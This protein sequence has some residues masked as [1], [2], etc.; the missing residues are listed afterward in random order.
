MS[1]ATKDAVDEIQVW[2]DVMTS[3]E[4]ETLPVA[5]P[6]ALVATALAHFSAD[7]VASGLTVG[8]A[9]EHIAAIMWGEGDFDAYTAE[10]SWNIGKQG[11]RGDATGLL[12]GIG[13]GVE[14]GLSGSALIACGVDGYVG[15]CIREG[16]DAGVAAINNRLASESID[17]L[18]DPASARA[19]LTRTQLPTVDDYQH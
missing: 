15:H 17:Y 3:V 14:A 5:D 10:P 16:A 13:R 7:F 11:Y 9:I 12:I 2:V 18:Y 19:A 8:D 4:L 1:A 6:A